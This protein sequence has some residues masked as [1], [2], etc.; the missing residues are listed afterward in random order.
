MTAGAFSVLDYII[1]ALM[2]AISAG[3]GI[4]YGCFGSK[5]STAKEVLVANR[6]MGVFPTAMSLLAS[7]MS[8]ITILGNPAE[9]YNYGT[10]FWWSGVA[11]TLACT[12]SA[13]IFMPVNF[14]FLIHF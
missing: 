6:Q 12:V 13:F 3:I 2:L 4:F 7:F 8:G 9:T 14:S 5:N 10:M 1:F 11:Y